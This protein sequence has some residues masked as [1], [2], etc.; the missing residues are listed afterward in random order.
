MTLSTPCAAPD[1]VTDEEL[2]DLRNRL[3]RFRS[4]RGAGPTRGIASTRI[5]RLAERWQNRFQW[6]SVESACRQLGSTMMKRRDGRHLHLLHMRSRDNS[7]RLPIVLLHGWPNTALMYRYVIPLLV[8]G[9]HDVVAPSLPGFGWSD[10]HAE[11]TS[12]AAMTDDVHLMMLEL[13]YTRY[14]VHG[15]DFG[16]AIAA[17]AATTYA[18]HVSAL[19]LLQPPFDRAFLVDRESVADDE[20]TFLE[21]LDAWAERAD[22]LGVH[23]RQAD[24]LGVALNDS[25]VGLL[26]WIAD[27]YDSWSGGVN[28]DDIIASVATMW[29]ARCARSSM[30]LYSEPEGAWG[31]DTSDENAWGS[32]ESSESAEPASWSGVDG[33]ATWTPR[34]VEA[35]TAFALF[36]NDI[37]QPP[38][39]FLDRF[40]AVKRFTTM[41]RGGH[42]AALDEPEALAND[43]IA[44]LAAEAKNTA[45]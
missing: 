19:H 7:G 44:F 43:L 40:F 35:P 2:A 16:A 18:A 34:R 21:G 10:E 20:R 6:S 22:Y 38:R 42:W 25:P 32:D 31:A 17:Q 24:T 28:D 1:P 9:G 26:A 14:A 5:A 37:M 3:H 45:A 12:I 4:I 27:K 11:E 15:T 23:N 13:G 29:F 41:P 30:R 36:P 39:A 33:H 8:G